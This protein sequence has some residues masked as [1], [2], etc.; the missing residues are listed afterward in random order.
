MELITTG[1]ARPYLTQA[2]IEE[3]DRVFQYKRPQHLDKKRV[4][5]VRR[6]LEQ[7]ATQVKS[8]GRLKIS[9]HEDDNR[10]YEC[11]LAAKADYIITENT[12]HF[13]HPHAYTKI[14]TARQLLRL[15]EENKA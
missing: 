4:T 1:K 10:I 12:K 8:S 15:V 5:R 6:L 3:Y 7:T 14:V 9:E 2:V 11:A 13:Q